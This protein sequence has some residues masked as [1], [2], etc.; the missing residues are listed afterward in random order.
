M[1][2]LYGAFDR[3]GARQGGGADLSGELAG[4]MCAGNCVPALGRDAGGSHVL[5]LAGG[6][7]LAL[8]GTDDAAA[9]DQL[10]TVTETQDASGIFEGTVIFPPAD[11][12]P[13]HRPG[14]AKGDT[15]TARHGEHALPGTHARNDGSSSRARRYP[16]RS[17]PC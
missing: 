6:A 7:S 11:Q 15:V 4:L 17:C 14:V 12:S 16:A 5:S 9:A 1:G 8:S 13:G 10:V 2:L 3:N